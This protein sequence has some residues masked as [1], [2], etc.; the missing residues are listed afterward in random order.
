MG[1]FRSRERL[2]VKV[3]IALDNGGLLPVGDMD[4]PLAPAVAAALQPN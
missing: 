4:Q 3:Q 1:R 2:T